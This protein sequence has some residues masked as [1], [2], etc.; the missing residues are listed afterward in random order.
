MRQR[1]SINQWVSA[2]AVLGLM[3]LFSISHAQELLDPTAPPA[4][5]DSALQEGVPQ[6]DADATA[7]TV[8]PGPVLIVRRA[9]AGEWRARALV[10][11]TLVSTG[12]DIEQ[13]E[14]LSIDRD[15]LRLGNAEGQDEVLRVVAA[16][17]K[18]H[19]PGQTHS[20]QE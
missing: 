12:D 18:K 1:K 10:R 7:S 16:G 11:G 4:E 2:L 3:L 5:V 9:T 15:G 8:R 13:G 14:I 20:E 19:R 6:L 17:V